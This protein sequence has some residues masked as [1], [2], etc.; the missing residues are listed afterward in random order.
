[1]VPSAHLTTVWSAM[2]VSNAASNAMLRSLIHT[3][4]ITIASGVL[5]AAFPR[6]GRM[7]YGTTH[8]VVKVEAGGLAMK[9]SATFNSRPAGRPRTAS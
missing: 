3:L 7:V 2:R 5:T 1:M 9:G 4:N 8:M 6:D